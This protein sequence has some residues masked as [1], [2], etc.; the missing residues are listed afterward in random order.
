[1]VFLFLSFSFLRNLHTAFHSDFIHLHSHQQC[2]WV[3][4]SP[5]PFQYFYFLYF[6]EQP[7]W[8]AWGD[9]SLW[10]AV[11]RFLKKLKLKNRNTIRLVIPLLGIYWK[12]TKSLFWKDICMPLFIATL[13]KIIKI[14]KQPTCISRWKDKEE[15]RWYINTIEYY[16]ALKRKKSCELWQHGWT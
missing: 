13:F 6:V 12:K 1:M 3:S 10:K 16:S 7:F 11:W 14:W 4:I 5:H 15:E 2:R 8:L 9:I